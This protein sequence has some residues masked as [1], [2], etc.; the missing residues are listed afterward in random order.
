MQMKTFVYFI[1]VFV[2]AVPV[3]AQI[4]GSGAL[5]GR[6]RGCP[7]IPALSSDACLG[8]KIVRGGTGPDGYPLPQ[9]C[10]ENEPGGLLQRIKE[11]GGKL[12]QERAEIKTEIRD[13]R[14]A[15]KN[16]FREAIEANRNEFRNT[17]EQKREELKAKIEMEKEQLRE[18]LMKIKDGKKR[19]IVERIS[20]QIADLNKKI[21]D[22]FSDALV[23]LENVLVNINDRADKTEAKGLNVDSVS[24]AINSAKSKIENARVAIQTQASKLY[25]ITVSSENALKLDVGVSRQALQNDLKQLQNVVRE[26]KNAVHD[27]A[28]TLAGIV[29]ENVPQPAGVSPD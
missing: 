3:F 2:V 8:G 9:K 14:N 7:P 28:T 20:Q 27:A 5:P 16:E 26:T 6:V 15:A 19:E 1:L 29:N 4:D 18:R 23:K 17:I 25:S 21:T 11:V 22:H 13:A 12:I 24:L 10:G